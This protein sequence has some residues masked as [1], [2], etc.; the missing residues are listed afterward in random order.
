MRKRWILSIIGFLFF[1]VSGIS[2][3]LAASDYPTRYIDLVIPYAPGGSTDL[4]PR[5]FKDKVEK[6]LGQP[7]VFTYKPGASGVMA[8]AYV[9]GCKPDGYTLLVTSVTTLVTSQIISKRP[10][11]YTLDDFTPICNLSYAPLTFSVK[12][13]SPYKTM[14]E[15]IKVAKTKKM[16]Y[17]TTATFSQAHVAMDALG[18]A[19]GFTAIHIPYSSGSASGQTAVLGGHVDMSVAAAGGLEGAGR[20]RILAVAQENRWGLHP[21]VPTLKEL[22]YP[23]SVELYQSLWA[24]KGTPKEIVDRIYGAFKKVAEDNKEEMTQLLNR[25]DKVLQLLGPQELIRVYRDQ[26]E[27]FKKEFEKMTRGAK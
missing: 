7:F 25:S 5:F 8:T 1:C 6:I 22:G 12:D 9:K 26:S 24:P 17:S 2:L 20:L 11:E 27:F 18:R 19:A 23:I 14:E 21:D 15:F 16:Q 4:V 10:A 13:E 3:A